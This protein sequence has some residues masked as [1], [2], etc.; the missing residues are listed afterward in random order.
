MY[1]S[2]ADATAPPKM[3][4]SVCI[5]IASSWARIGVASRQTTATARTVPLSMIGRYSRIT[6]AFASGASGWL[7]V[8]DI[9]SAWTFRLATAA[10]NF[11][12]I[13][14]LVAGPAALEAMSVLSGR[15]SAAARMSS[16]VVRAAIPALSDVT[17][18]GASVP[19]ATSVSCKFIATKLRRAAASP[20][21]AE[22][23]SVVNS[24]VVVRKTWPD[25]VTATISRNPAMTRSR[26]SG[27]TR[28]ARPLVSSTRFRPMRMPGTVRPRPGGGYRTNVSLGR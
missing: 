3:T 13:A 11:G 16:S 23:R 18:A 14:M 26:S 20:P 19:G 17:R 22:L 5:R 1:T 4:R 7:S 24:S 21:T 27:R 2:T 12:V 10:A 28:T 25:A 8:A 6:V 15:R 9:M